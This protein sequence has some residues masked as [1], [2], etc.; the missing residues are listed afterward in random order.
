M[1][2][3]TGTVAL[4]A[5]SDTVTGTGTA[6]KTEEIPVGAAFTLFGFP[7]PVQVKQVISDTQLK[8]SRPIKGLAINIAGAAYAISTDYTPYCNIPYPADGDPEGMELINR[9]FRDIDLLLG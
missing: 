1:R 7:T 5:S 3:S 6:W 9:A 4:S 8:L 2:Y